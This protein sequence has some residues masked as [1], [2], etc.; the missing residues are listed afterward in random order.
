MISLLCLAVAHLI[1]NIGGVTF[2]QSDVL[3]TP[4]A[5]FM[6][7]NFG[8]FI[9]KYNEIHEEDLI[10]TRLFRLRNQIIFI[11]NCLKYL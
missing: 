1:R 2:F 4:I 3:K 10:T 7:Q 9:Y 11:F 5:E 8:T 6:S